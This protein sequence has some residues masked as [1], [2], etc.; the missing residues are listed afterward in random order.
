M[1]E[2]AVSMG[3]KI[4]VVATVLSTMNPSCDLINN[5][6]KSKKKQIE[7]IQGLVDGALDILLKDEDQKRHNEM[8]LEKIN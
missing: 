7:I 2:K 4:G 6:A 8:V 3:S 5:V 1:A